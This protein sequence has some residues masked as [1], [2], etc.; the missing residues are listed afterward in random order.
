[1]ITV[2][3]VEDDTVFRTTLI[4]DLN[5]SGICRVVNASIT[6]EG[7]RAAWPA[8]A[9]D[10]ALVD[11]GLPGISGVALIAALAPELPR[12]AFVVLTSAEDDE[13]IFEALKAGAVGYLLKTSDTPAIVAALTDAHRG[14]SPMS[15]RIARRVVR[16]FAQPGAPKP[17]DEVAL[18]SPRE[19]EVLACLAR[20]LAYKNIAGE[21]GL[22]EETIRTHIRG[23]YRKLQVN[24]RTEAVLKYLGR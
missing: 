17:A 3:L 22:G 1:M 23:I 8:K 5:A 16:R 9:P 15:W 13:S 20:G 4:R 10:V 21:L 19:N 14:G 11:L 12:T 7:A 18:L 6:A 2:A 24:S